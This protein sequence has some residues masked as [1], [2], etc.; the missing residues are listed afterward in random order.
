MH[1]P[2]DLLSPCICLWIFSPH[3]SAS[4][5][6]LPMHLPLD[7]LSSCICLWISAPHVS[8]FV[9]QKSAG[10][11]PG[12]YLF[13]GDQYQKKIKCIYCGCRHLMKDKSDVGKRRV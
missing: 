1:L 10:A 7:L 8:A 9:S 4:G 12:Q 6:P 5:S 11:G 13:V 3:A 2:L